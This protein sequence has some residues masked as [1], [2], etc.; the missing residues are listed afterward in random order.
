MKRLKKIK[1]S[2][3]SRQLSTAKLSIKTAKD[4]YSTAKGES[5]KDNLRNAFQGNIDQ[6]VEELDLMKGSLMK[7]GQMLSLFGG[8]FLPEELKLVLKKLENKSS[9]LVWDEIKKEIPSHWLDELDIATEPL[10]SASLGQ[11]HM[12][13]VDG[14]EFCMKIQYRGVKKAINNDIR[15]LKLLLKLLKFVPSN[16]NMDEIFVEI[17]KMLLLE[18][19]YQQEAKTTGNFRE[20]LADEPCF[21]IPEVLHRYSNSTVLTTEFIKGESLHHIEDLGLSQE[22]RNMLGREFM[23][24]FLM[25]VFIFGKIQTDSHFGN[26]LIITEPELKWG[27]I[28]FG[29]TKV[30]PENFLRNYQKLILSLKDKSRDEFIKTVISMGYLADHKENDLELFWEYAQVIGSP[31][32]DGDFNWGETNIAD[33]VFE[34]LPKLMKSI[35]VGNPPAD[36]IFLDRKLGGV[37]FVLQKLKSNFNLNELIEEVL[38]MDSV[39]SWEE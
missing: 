31:F 9:F 22:Q 16:V 25:E 1:N 34:F 21:Y 11:V 35:S 6:I 36:T 8:A 17:K 13:K 26:Y 3:I 39:L 24:L 29:A 4:F 33:Q 12:V 38:R 18:T 5:L 28:D 30:P 37:F 19:D 14:K 27:L 32:I 7:A 20:L 15:T 23:R 10:A 2:F